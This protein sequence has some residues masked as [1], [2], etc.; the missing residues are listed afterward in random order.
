M[1]RVRRSRNQLARARRIACLSTAPWNPYLRLLYE[2]VAAQG[3]EVV[4]D[5]EFSLGWLWRARSRVG[6]LH[7]HWPE[8]H[9]LYGRGPAR[10]RPLL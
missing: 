1:P 10:L 5:P 2:H 4:E 9:Y 7:F 6:F 8:G 3:F